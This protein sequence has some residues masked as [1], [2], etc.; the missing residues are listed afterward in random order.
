MI[1]E[2]C[3]LH[4][5]AYEKLN[6]WCK[7]YYIP[8]IPYKVEIQKINVVKFYVHISPVFSCQVNFNSTSSPSDMA[9]I[10]SSL[11]YV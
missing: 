7:V 6:Q 2:I 8:M 3:K 11:S 10:L 9:S 5:I 1:L 4:E